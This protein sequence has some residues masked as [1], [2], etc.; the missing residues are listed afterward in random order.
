MI[1]AIAFVPLLDVILAFNA[2]CMDCGA[3]GN[4]QVILQ[5]FERNYIGDLRAGVRIAPAFPHELWGVHEQVMNG[6]PRTTNAVEAW[7]LSVKRCVRQCHAAIWKFIE[8]LKRE[9]ASMHLII[10][11]GIA[12]VPS[13]PQKRRCMP[14][15]ATHVFYFDCHR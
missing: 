9:Y 13:P 1:G 11:H 15:I 10:A 2:L 8:C 4:E 12:G 14:W 6:L 5:Y 7:H 3:N